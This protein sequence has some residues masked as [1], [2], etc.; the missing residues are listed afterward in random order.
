MYT[1]YILSV[2]NNP[3]NTINGSHGYRNIQYWYKHV[4]LMT[5]LNHCIISHFSLSRCNGDSIYCYNCHKYLHHYSWIV[6]GLWH[7]SFMS[8]RYQYGIKI[9]FPRSMSD[10][11]APAG[12]FTQT[13]RWYLCLDYSHLFTWHW[14]SIIQW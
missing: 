6:N 3:N 1:H 2:H 8:M 13:K 9:T 7:S 11:N 4:A 12:V 5:S 10:K 14:Y